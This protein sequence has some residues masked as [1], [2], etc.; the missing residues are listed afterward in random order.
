MQAL[1]KTHLELIEDGIK[2]VRA[3]V[4]HLRDESDLP[5]RPTLA[6]LDRVEEELDYATR[7]RETAGNMFPSGARP[8]V[9][10]EITPEE[11]AVR[12]REIEAITQGQHQWI[13]GDKS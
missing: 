3:L 7:P 8:Y 2:L 11:R 4:Q 9:P 5:L 12:D 13:L 10:Q 1:V 6:A